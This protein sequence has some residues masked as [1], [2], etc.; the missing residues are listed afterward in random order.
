MLLRLGRTF[1]EMV[2]QDKARAAFERLRAK[3]PADYRATKAALYLA[4]IDKRFGP[5]PAPAPD[6]TPPSLEET[7]P[8]EAPP[9]P[10]LEA[11]PPAPTGSATP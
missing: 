1:L 8:P 11:Q 9:E 3:Y 5:R 2:D 7:A 4:H 10:P 6:A